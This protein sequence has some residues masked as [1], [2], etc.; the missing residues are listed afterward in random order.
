MLSKLIYNLNEENYS[1]CPENLTGERGGAARAIEGTGSY[2]SRSLGPGYKMSPSIC[3]KAKEEAV[4][5]KIDGSGE[6]RH[7]WIT[8]PVEAWR[9]LVLECFWDDEVEPSI[10]V[11]VGDFFCNGWCE[12]V[13][14]NSIPIIVAPRGGFNSYWPMPFT[15]SARLVLKNRH[16]NDC[17]I[18]YQ[19]DY[20]KKRFKEEV[21]TF[22]G[23][24]RRSNPV[25]KKS[26]HIILDSVE[27]FGH[28]V[29]MYMAWQS[30]SCDW[31]GE[32]EVKFYLDEDKDYPSICSTGTEDYFGGAYNFAENRS[33]QC[34]SAPYMGLHQVIRPDGLYR[35][36]QRF[37][38]YRWHIMDSISFRERIR[39]EIQPLGVQYNN[40]YM[41]LQD[42][43]A[44][45][46]FWYQKEP[47]KNFPDFPD[48]DEC[49]VSREIDWEHCD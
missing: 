27:G 3:I 12:P 23:Q 20:V 15:K 45:T 49:Y 42:D 17:I 13:N 1:I 30:N 37:G 39:I 48:E 19:I 2:F 33:Y 28:Y 29:G 16:Y 22:H 18:Y 14:V 40:K 31:W 10:Q 41:L 21:L 5:A 46:V 44:T 4:L 32:G 35:S 24:F 6:I 34:Y 11:P 26:P 47:H 36:Q 43:V 38:M 7:I 8:C 9:D 25:S